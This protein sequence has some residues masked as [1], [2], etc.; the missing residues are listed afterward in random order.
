MVRKYIV[1]RVAEAK[2]VLARK[3]SSV[4]RLDRVTGHCRTMR[5]VQALFE[6]VLRRAWIAQ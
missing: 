6:G 4:R 3:E 5:R 1:Y 2:T